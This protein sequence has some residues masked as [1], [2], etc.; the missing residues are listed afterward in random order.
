M[1]ASDSAPPAPL[2]RQRL[3]VDVVCVGFGPAM[4]GF[5][6]TLARQLL[7]PD[8]TPA[9][10]SAVQPGL[11]PQ[12]ICYER[13]GDI[14]FGVSGVVTRARALRRTFPDIDTAPIPMAHPVVREKVLYLLDPGGAS[15]RS[16]VLLAADRI[17]RTFG[18]ALPLEHEALDLPWTPRFLHKCGGLVLSMGQFM[19]WVGAQVQSA[20]TVQIWPGT[21][22]AQALLDHDRV[23]GIRLVDQGVDAQGHPEAGFMPGMDIGA[24]LTVVGDGPVG[25]VGRQLDQHFGL[26]PGHHTRDWA[27]GM[28]FV[29]DLPADTPLEPGTVLHTFGYPEPEI[30]GFLYVHPERVASLG[31]FVP[32]WFD[33]PMRTAYRYLQHWMLHPYL[34]RHLKGGKLRSWGA[35][36]LGESGRRGEPFLA[37]DGYARIGEGSGSTNVLTGSG[38]DEA[39]ATGAQLA[40]GVLELLAAR[41]PFTKANLEAAYIRRRRS[42]WVEREARIA[43]N[44]RDGFHAGIVRGMLGMALAGMTGGRFSMKGNPVPPHQRIPTVEEYYRGRIPPRELDAIRRDCEARGVP[45]HPVLMER[46]GWPAIP[47]DGQLLV[48]HQDALLLGGKV[49][50]PAGYADHVSFI[51]PQLCV[52]CGARL[53]V[54]ACSG[55]AIAPGDHGVPT[56]D[57]EKCVHCGA[58]LWNCSQ[59]LPGH[60]EQAN[61]VFRAGPGGL[62]STE[63]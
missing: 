27:L 25:A 30:F 34:W 57:R 54:E 8:G 14:G 10:E 38:V 19:Q 9:A 48:S 15:R 37:G 60:P 1:D 47:Y 56:F 23:V 17:L 40:E 29:V 16:R 26:P 61:I 12:V 32:S 59:H 44:S 21:P 41:K 50:A 52:Q 35:K 45:L 28:K 33:S 63:N 20:G 6:A 24:A 36:T 3:D 42:S 11:P 18:W 31:I 51:D 43:E 46:V 55:Q 13:A 5:L 39:W 2:E 22:V 53:C 4:G 62:H 49:Q 7:K 58:C